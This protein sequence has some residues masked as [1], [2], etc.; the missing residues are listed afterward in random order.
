[1]KARGKIIGEVFSDFVCIDV[2]NN[3][4]DYVL[5]STIYMKQL[6]TK[7]Y[8]LIYVLQLYKMAEWGFIWCMPT[9]T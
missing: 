6:H 1:M 5:S 8:K 9:I 2:G 7:I 3:Y 4:Y